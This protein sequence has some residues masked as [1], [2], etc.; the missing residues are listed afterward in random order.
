MFT[1]E[2]QIHVGIEEKSII[3][4]LSLLKILMFCSL[5]MFVLI[6]IKFCFANTFFQSYWGITDMEHF[7]SLR[8]TMNW[9]DT[10]TYCKMNITIV[11]AT[12][13]IRLYISFPSFV[14]KKFQ[15][16]LSNFQVCITELLT[17]ITVLYIRVPK[18][19]YLKTE[20]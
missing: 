1:I 16:S 15:Y 20:S 6:F 8:C 18:L 13:S 11:L 14:V 4:I 3:L 12:T 17:I 19:L 7:V 5:C 2:V 9:F 10:F